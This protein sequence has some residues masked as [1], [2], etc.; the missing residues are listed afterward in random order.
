LPPE[1]AALAYSLPATG[2]KRTLKTHTFELDGRCSLSK[3]RRCF[4]FSIFLEKEGTDQ[5]VNAQGAHGTLKPGLH[6]LRSSNPP[7]CFTPSPASLS[8]PPRRSPSTSRSAALSLSAKLQPTKPLRSLRPLS[9]H[10]VSPLCCLQPSASFPT[11][12]LLPSSPRSLQA[13][14][15]PLVQSCRCSVVLI[16]PL[17]QKN[18]RVASHFHKAKIR[19]HEIQRIERKSH[20]TMCFE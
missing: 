11:A 13:I 14:V 4:R 7:S 2:K 15:S 9:P 3:A 19:A 12:A 5:S 8:S 17:F 1:K 10:A 6:E 20:R 18:I 16:V